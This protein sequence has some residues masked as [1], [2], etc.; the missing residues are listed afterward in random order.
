MT[1]RRC[2]RSFDLDDVHL[3]IQVPERYFTVLYSTVQYCIQM[4]VLLTQTTS[5]DLLIHQR[6]NCPERKSRWTPLR[7]GDRHSQCWPER[8]GRQQS[9]SWIFAFRGE[10]IWFDWFSF[11]CVRERWE[12]PSGYRDAGGGASGRVWAVLCSRSLRAR[13]G[14]CLACRDGGSSRVY[15]KCSPNTHRNVAAVNPSF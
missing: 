15:V 4:T 7:G 1:T 5:N 11:C 8:R 14:S 3:A 2:D 9:P 10:L 13:C 12:E 6:R